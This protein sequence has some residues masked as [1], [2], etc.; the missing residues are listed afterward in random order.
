MQE[1]SDDLVKKYCSIKVDPME[2]ERLYTVSDMI[3]KPTSPEQI[4]SNF[5]ILGRCV[6]PPQIFDILEHTEAGVGG[7]LQLTDAMCTLARTEGMYGV[8][9]EGHRYDM[10]N[11]LGVLQAIME[12][13][14]NHPEIGDDFR[15]Y[16]K[17]L[18]ATL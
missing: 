14:L 7:E 10:G 15:A 1:V 9:F 18:A 2:Q 5:A 11:K 17:E 12:V 16:L 13:G 3:E 6:L 4:F 8:D